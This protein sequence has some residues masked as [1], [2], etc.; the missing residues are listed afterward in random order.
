MTAQREAD[1]ATTTQERA[2]ASTVTPPSL[3]APLRRIGPVNS[4]R[5][6]LILAWRNITQLKHSPDK[7]GDV[8][9]MPIVFT[10]LFLFVFGGAVAGSTHAYLQQL[11][12][13]MVAQMTL[14]TSV[15]VGTVLCEDIQK[16]VFDRFRSMPI[17]RSAPLVGSVLGS[18]VRWVVSM[19][20]LVGFG[21]ALGFRFSAS[22]LSILV[23]FALAYGFYLSFCW[24]SVLI[25]L[26]ARSPGT[27]QGLALV[28]A[29]PLSFGSSI[30]VANIK[31]MP[32]WLQAWVR[33]NPV[34][35]FADTV[36][37]LTIGG[38]IGDKAVYALVWAAGII[39]VG[40][41]VAMVTYRRRM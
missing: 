38:P 34:S 33:I 28:I 36:R 41:P 8:V 13:G 29:L 6:G 39:V 20:V 21:S 19:A 40:F 14:F 9:L 24:I 15:T 16:G 25:G 30:L 5:H 37:A 23:A 17:A 3:V 32:G 4:A 10:V 27:V 1:E 26:V 35:Y 7:L 12:P 11:L 22:P 31:T 2:T 18:A